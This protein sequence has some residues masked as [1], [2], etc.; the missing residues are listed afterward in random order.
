MN[1]LSP[2][3]GRSRLITSRSVLNL[4]SLDVMNAITPVTLRPLT[5]CVDQGRGSTVTQ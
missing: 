1:G 2:M 3:R 5:R 4:V